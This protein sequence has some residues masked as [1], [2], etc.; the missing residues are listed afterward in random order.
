MPSARTA[1]CGSCLSRILSSLISL[2]NHAAFR[3]L[4]E[5]SHAISLVRTF[6][7]TNASNKHHQNKSWDRW[8]QK[9]KA[10]GVKN[11]SRGASVSA[12]YNPGARIGSRP[13]L[14]GRKQFEAGIT[15]KTWERKDNPNYNVDGEETQVQNGFAARERLPW[16]TQKEALEKKFPEGYQPR[17]RLSPDALEGIRAIH[18]QDPDR[19]ST[20]VLSQYFKVSPE[21]IRRILRTKWKPNT[22]E[23]EERRERWEKRG[24]KIWE[25]L[26]ELGVKPPK[27]WREM[28]V[29]RAVAGQLPKW[30]DPGIKR[31]MKINY[32]GL[33]D[34][35]DMQDSPS[36]KEDSES[37]TV[38]R[39][40]N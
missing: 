24:E 15:G 30:K 34:W 2:H 11:G 39:P 4:N 22:E 8:D 40:K 18:A 1:Y 35:I 28:G 5:R 9:V 37:S 31:G 12:T 17:K 21:A 6:S 25:N 23:A 33:D 7:T 14:K 20:P 26:V 10:E 19:F 36:P 27:K 13:Q 3:A 32:A 29:G 38:S 16:Q